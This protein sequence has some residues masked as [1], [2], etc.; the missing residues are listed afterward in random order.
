MIY[1]RFIDVWLVVVL[2]TFDLSSLLLQR[3]NVRCLIATFYPYKDDSYIQDRF[4]QSKISNYGRH[5]FIKFI[6]FL[7][8]Y[9]AINMYIISSYMVF[10]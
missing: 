4:Y 1:R 10:S 2:S 3:D 6:G 7:L 9:Y 5:Y 8:I